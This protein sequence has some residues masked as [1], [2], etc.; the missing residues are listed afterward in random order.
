LKRRAWR[1][2]NEVPTSY[3]VMTEKRKGRCSDRRGR[4]KNR[5]KEPLFRE[6]RG[7][8]VAPIKE[9]KVSPQGGPNKGG[10]GG[11]G[12]GDFGKRGSHNHP[13]SRSG[14]GSP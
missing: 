4:K 12:G 5:L 11:G 8:P 6:G 9:K 7:T 3:H 13:D 10:G 2:P 14:T 1:T